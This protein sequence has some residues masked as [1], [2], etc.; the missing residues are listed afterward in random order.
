MKKCLFVLVALIVGCSVRETPEP[1]QITGN[2]SI[3]P[4]PLSIGRLPGE[5][6][7]TPDTKIVASDDAG[8]RLASRLNEELRNNLGF[9]LGMTDDAD[10]ADAITFATLPNEAIS[11]PEE[12]LLRVE[13]EHIRI[14]GSERG[15]FYG[16]QS[17]VKLLNLESKGTVTIPAAEIYDAPRFRYRGMHLDV[18]RHFMSVDFVKK[19]IRLLSQYK[20]NYFHWHLTDDQG[21]R[22][23]IKKY[24]RLTEIGSKRPETVLEKNYHPYIGDRIPVEGFY[25]QE[26]IRE[27]VKYA[28]ERY[29]TIVPEIDL[30]GHSSAALA[31]YPQFGCKKVYP[32]RVKTTW[33]AFPDVYCPT[34]ETF[35]F[36]QDV[37][38]EVID[39]FPESPYLHIGGDEIIADHWKESAFVQGLKKTENLKT[40]REVQDWFLQRV[41]S[42]VRS[43]G[44]TIIGWD[45]LLDGKVSASA[46]IMSWRGMEAGIRAAK[47]HHETIMA[48][49]SFAY[50][51]HPQDQ[52]GN[53]P[54]SLGNPVPIEKV[55]S[56]EPVAT[57]ISHEDAKYIL[58]AEG[59]V[60][61]EFIRGP[62]NVE[63]MAFPRAIALAEV[64]WS[65]VA[66]RNYEDFSDR[67]AVELLRLDRQI[68]N[69]RNPK[70]AVVS[71]K[72]KDHR[73]RKS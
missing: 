24:P 10:A 16:I 51:D 64:L 20:F 31:S 65:P 7:L 13:S 72:S 68:V 33:G 9:E 27:I 67:L 49:D 37:L 18:S 6:L 5:F 45:E 61:T 32:Y 48:P 23:E 71:P 63:Y 22:I 1:K 59:C 57:G 62:K 19:Y 40:E 66:V 44:K 38:G 50:F 15:M 58:G 14:I 12:Y 55:Y 17:L 2:I 4:H 41:E 53:E 3:I 21:W 8:M 43:R 60:W 29:V 25:S 52:P 70:H 56:F 11:N 73:N 30:P 54:L 35:Q 39:L 26:E 28:K 42:Y 34:E 36:I 46:T 47:S 69:Y